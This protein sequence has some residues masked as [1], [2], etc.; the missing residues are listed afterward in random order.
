MKLPYLIHRAALLLPLAALLALPV[1][2]TAQETRPAS[3]TARIGYSIGGTTPLGMPASIRSLISFNPR[4]NIVLGVDYTKPFSNLWGV[5]AGLRFENKGMKT[6]ANV[7]TYQMEMRKGSDF[8]S[9]V[10]TGG[11]VTEVDQ[12]MITVPILANLQVRKVAVRLGPYVS[13]V[14]SSNFSGYAY[15]GY[16]RQGNPVGPKV[17]IGSAPGT[18]GDYDFSDELRHAQFGLMAG[19]DWHFASHIGA[20]VDLS[21]GLTGVFKDSFKTIEQTMFPIYGALG[22]T[23]C[24]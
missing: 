23:Y 24:F 11:V 3:I 20:F 17:I 5:R 21:W 16:I 9:G 13:F 7:K 8:I 6:D 2:L 22:L 1:H 18:R 12:W 10:F 15:D 14:L 19:A 4:A